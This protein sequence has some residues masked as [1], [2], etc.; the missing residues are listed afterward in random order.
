MSQLDLAVAAGI[1]LASVKRSEL[2]ERVTVKTLE[3]LRL[4]LEDNGVLFVP[5]SPKNGPGL[6]LPSASS[7][8]QML[9]V[10]AV[11]LGWSVEELA[12]RSRIGE[13]TLVAARTRDRVGGKV[14]H[15]TVARVREAL[16]LAGVRFLQPSSDHG[17]GFTIPLASL[18]RDDLRF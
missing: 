11:A 14:S 18:S 10:A 9:T 5:S 7:E 17:P 3:A 8:L 15:R 16:E 1:A 6:R 12:V 2:N 13:R 4:P